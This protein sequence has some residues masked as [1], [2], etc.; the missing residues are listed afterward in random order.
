MRLITMEQLCD[1]LSCGRSTV[2]KIMDAGGLPLPVRLPSGGVRWVEED[3]EAMLSSFSTDINDNGR[4]IMLSL[5]N[6][7]FVDA[8]IVNDSGSDYVGLFESLPDAVRAANAQ[9]M[10]VYGETFRIAVLREKN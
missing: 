8:Q 2:Y 9:A 7:G 4:T 3:V 1:K 5:R 6:E 10:R